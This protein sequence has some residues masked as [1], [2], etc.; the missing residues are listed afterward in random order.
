V[1]TSGPRGLA[2]LVAHWEAEQGNP[3]RLTAAPA[4]DP[5]TTAAGLQQALERLLLTE[6]DRHG[7]EVDAG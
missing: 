7:I 1:R 2:G 6:L 4:S 5:A 3:A